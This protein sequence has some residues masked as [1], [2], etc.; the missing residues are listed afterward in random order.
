MAGI[1]P[2]PGPTNPNCPV[3]KK[4]VNWK[5]KSVFCTKCKAWCHVRKKDNCSGL[6]NHRDYNNTWKCPPCLQQQ[7]IKQPEPEFIDFKILQFNCN[8]LRNK[9]TEI[10]NWMKKKEIKIA[11]FQETKLSEKVQ[12]NDLGDF[13]LIRKDRLKDTGGGVAFLIHKNISFQIL[14]N[15]NDEHA[16]YQA[17]KINN[18]QIINL[19]IPP[20][21]SCAAG[22]TPS[23]S[24]FLPTSDAIV[25]GDLNAHDT[26]WNSSIQD[27]RGAVFAEEIGNSDF[28]VLNTEKAT[29][30][31]TNGQPTSPDVSLASFSLLPV[32]DWDT[33]TTFGSDHL[34]VIISVSARI[35]K[36][37]SEKKTFTNFN[38]A[39][40]NDYTKLT[41]EEFSKCPEPTD[42][43]AA[44]IRFRKIINKVSKICIPSGRIK[45]VYPGIPTEAA[46]KMELR[47]TLRTS[48]PTS[49]EIPRLNNE[50]S[51]LIFEHKK[52]KWKKTVEEISPNSSKLFKLIKRLNGKNSISGNQPIKFKGKYISCPAKIANNFNKQYSA[53][54]HHKSSR[55]SRIVKDNIMKNNLET[56]ELHTDEATKEAI[57]NSKASKALGPDKMS[58]LHLKHLGPFGINYLTK[59]FNLSVSSSQ[60]PAIWKKSLIV[61]LPKPGKDHSE[62][63]SYRPVSL[64][65]PAI[66]ILERLI[67]PT[68]DEH[69]EVPSFQHGF[70]KNHSTVTA[71][72]DFNKA[73]TDGFNLNPPPDRT[74]LVQLDLSKAFDMVNH[75]KLINGL[76]ETSLPGHIK[77]WLNCYLRGRQSCVQFRNKKSSS[78]NVRTGV[79]QGAVLSPLLFSFYLAKIP[80]PPKGIEIVQYADDISIYASGTN[81]DAL[82]SQINVYLETLLNFLE[83]RELLVSPEK[84]TVTLFSPDTKDYKIHP[85]VFLRNQLVR[86]ENKPKLLGV[87]FDTLHKFCHHIQ[88]AID[89]AKKKVN[90]LKCLAGTNWGCD[91]KTI[92]NTYKS[93]CR[94]VLEY[95]CQIWAPIISPHLWNKLQIIQNQALKI[96]TGC[97][98]IASLDHIHHE[99]KVL[100]IQPHA[101]LLTKQFLLTNHLPGHPG[102]KHLDRP[103]PPRNMKKTI[104]HYKDDIQQCLP[105]VD[106]PSHK[107]GLKHLHT[108]AVNRTIA[109]YADNRVLKR[110]APPLNTEEE[111]LPRKVRTELSRLRSGF[112]RNLN[113]YRNRLD[114]T[115]P[116]TCPLCNNSPHDVTHLFN[117]PN[118]PTTF[119]PT[120]LWNKPKEVASFLQ[121][122]NE[123]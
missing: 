97:L 108:T 41:E 101:M 79:P 106:K 78:R 44:E 80:L 42:V 45:E 8:G 72:H 113:D 119:T 71:L 36:S 110:K 16:E 109:N 105:V 87:T 40:W 14:P 48:N 117:C 25:V 64:L 20:T 114:P 112:S 22:Y 13:I 43:Y 19:Y 52:E 90:I 115:I 1:E 47:D 94:S 30:V 2:N 84:S 6:K 69:L 37:L 33:E 31:P 56:P 29:R 10:L 70:R 5:T 104:L 75:D 49:E 57:K 4:I 11:A 81:I 17:I 116:N 50:I 59:I 120:D 61:P 85:Q 62:S 92:I 123:T 39:K 86:L 53:V 26:L 67:L 54:V 122:N 58:N 103:P 27:P 24:K 63:T 100:P 18:I 34:P 82:T 95:G 55:F 83:E 121:L 12:L 9:V 93:I 74:V 3:C 28:G 76:N 60:I 89:N 32:C 38:K 23:L 65:C 118:N 35:E 111:S 15:I 96:A 77:R 99:T 98:K 68:L 73:V 102:Q 51:S 66:K 88:N 107:A 46:R 91:K 21:G 7:N